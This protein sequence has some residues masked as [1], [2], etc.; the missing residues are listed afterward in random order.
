LHHLNAGLRSVSFTPH[1]S[2]VL[3][4][5]SEA[6]SSCLGA[7]SAYSGSCP[8]GSLGPVGP[9]D[10]GVVPHPAGKATMRTVTVCDGRDGRMS[11]SGIRGGVDGLPHERE[12]PSDGDPRALARVKPLAA[13]RPSFGDLPHPLAGRAEARDVDLLGC[14]WQGGKVARWHLKEACPTKCRL[15]HFKLG[16]LGTVTTF[17]MPPLSPIRF[18]SKRK[19]RCSATRD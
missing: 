3:G 9:A 5:R 11:V 17:H 8:G 12:T 2:A 10:P 6:S 19:L 18:S 1:A 15:L 14:A 4:R 16:G 13:A 7:I